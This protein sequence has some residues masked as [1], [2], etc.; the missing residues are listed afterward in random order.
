MNQFIKRHRKKILPRID[1]G[2]QLVPHGGMSVQVYA[3]K[4]RKFVFAS[5]TDPKGQS[6]VIGLHSLSTLK[7]WTTPL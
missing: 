1:F 7:F 4:G 6:I 5:V 3:P 2:T